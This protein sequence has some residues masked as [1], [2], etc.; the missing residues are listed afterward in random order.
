MFHTEESPTTM[1]IV[2]FA[3]VRQRAIPVIRA[4]DPEK[5]YEPEFFAALA[6]KTGWRVGG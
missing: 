5:A 1:T 6:E 4:A 2:E 3:I